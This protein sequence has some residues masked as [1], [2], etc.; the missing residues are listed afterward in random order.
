MLETAMDILHT[1]RELIALGVALFLS[2]VVIKTYWDTISFW[3]MD[4]W[5]GLPLIGKIRRLSK[6]IDYNTHSKCFGSEETLADAYLSYYQREHFDPEYYDKCSSYLARAWD[7]GRKPLTP[8]MW[9]LIFLM[10]AVEAMGFSYVLAGF[11]IPGAS[12]NLL[13]IGAVGISFLIAMLLVWFTHLTG[14]ELYINSLVGKV[15]AIWKN[16]NDGKPLAGSDHEI[17][18]ETNNAD[19]AE[20]KYRQIINRVAFKG[21]VEKSHFITGGTI[22][23]V[24][25]VAILATVVRGIVLERELRAETTGAIEQVQQGSTN[26]F[27][28]TTLTEPQAKADAKSIEEGADLDRKGGWGTFIVLA[29]I[30]VFLQILGVLFGFMYGLAGRESQKAYETVFKYKTRAEYE[31]AYKAI[32]AHI[33]AMGSRRLIEL[34]RRLTQTVQKHGSEAAQRTAADSSEGRDIYTF[35]ERHLKRQ[36]GVD[37]LERSREASRT[38]HRQAAREP[39]RPAPAPVQ[40]P[41]PAAEAAG[42]E[43]TEEQ[44]EARIRAELVEE[45]RKK[46]VDAEQR[47]KEREDAIRAKILAERTSGNA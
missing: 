17:R 5:Y 27:F 12:E 8:L 3:L 46:G 7:T 39:A 41:A 11:T 4:L 16:A 14:H 31:A 20:P 19:D 45:E 26:S 38:A 34:Q 6:N 28:P 13:K 32:K 9:F 22:V 1:Y 36:D 23:F 21:N 40:A 47:R 30:F 15:R 37:A 18:I 10:M 25:T 33:L 29:I 42:I 44:M 43:E 35:L 2:V 24:I